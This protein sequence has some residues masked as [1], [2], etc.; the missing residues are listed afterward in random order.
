VVRPEFRELSNFAFYDFELGATVLGNPDLQRT[1]ITNADL[2]YEVY[3]RAGELFTLGVFYKYFD[4]P[5]E[6]YFNQSGAGSSNTFN[7]QNADN[8]K[9]FGV[10]F[11]MR[12]KLDFAESLENFTFTSNLSYIHNQVQFQNKSLNRPMQ[13]QSPYL[14][15]AGLQ[16]DIIKYG[17]NTTLLFN[18]IGRR[19]AYVGNDQ[20]PAIWEAPRPL[21]DFQFAKKI[22]KNK[23]ELK[24]NL[25][26]ILNSPT[27][28]YH[29]LNDDGRYGKVND[30]LAINRKYGTTFTITFGYN[31]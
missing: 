12:K 29:D 27:K 7:Y 3:P 25:S 2:R 26:D 23:G 16:Y 11:E 20:V 21:L 4:K 14:I 1:K 17:I 28:F 22:I 8:A 15:N 13:G 31:F 30:A 19:I 18:Q 10:E 5:I 6:V 9:G 24:L